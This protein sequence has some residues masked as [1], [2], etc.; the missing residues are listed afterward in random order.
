[1]GRLDTIQAAVLLEKLAIFEDEIGA[2][3]RIAERYNA[4]LAD[5]CTVPA[6]DPRA[7]SVWAQYTIRLPHG[8]RDDLAAVLQREGVPTAVYYRIPMHRQPA[9][10]HYPAAGNGLP[11]CETLA[12][13]VISLPMHPYL[14]EAAQERVIAAVRRALGA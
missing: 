1:T 6:V 3:Q 4:A 13:E 10:A 7:S 14:D 5:V 8:V 12:G 2:R 11:V 9:Y